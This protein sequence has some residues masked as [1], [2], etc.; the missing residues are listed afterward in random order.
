M[1]VVTVRGIVVLLL[2]MS[3]LCSADRALWALSYTSDTMD[4]KIQMEKKTFHAGEPISGKVI[5][6]SDI[7]TTYRATF[8]VKLYKDGLLLGESF[9]NTPLF[10]GETEYELKN[11]GI[12]ITNAGPEDKGHWRIVI[13]RLGEPENSAQAEFNIE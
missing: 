5:L 8:S 2:S 7:P 4:I 3:F 13:Y 11:F 6:D 10:F 12:G 9:H 1:K